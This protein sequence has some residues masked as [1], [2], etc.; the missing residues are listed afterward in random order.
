[1][2]DDDNDD[3]LDFSSDASEDFQFADDNDEDQQHQEQLADPNEPS[4]S[5]RGLARAVL[6][7]LREDVEDGVFSQSPSPG[8]LPTTLSQQIAELSAVDS[9]LMVSSLSLSL[10]LCACVWANCWWVSRSKLVSGAA[11]GWWVEN[12]PITLVPSTRRSEAAGDRQM[13]HSKTLECLNHQVHI[14]V[15]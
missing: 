4:P 11:K 12:A 15:Y 14:S 3:D 8:Q 7:N 9:E 6:P 2:S 13:H 5:L 1:M 10:S